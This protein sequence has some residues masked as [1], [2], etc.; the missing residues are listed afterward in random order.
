M[1]KPLCIFLNMILPGAGTL[2]LKRTLNGSL[3]LAMSLF[4][5]ILIFT[6]WLAFFGLVL[7]GF[8]WLWALLETI[9]IKDQPSAT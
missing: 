2:V 8:A 4:G 6:V 1:K 9:F 7:F 3:Q 5:I